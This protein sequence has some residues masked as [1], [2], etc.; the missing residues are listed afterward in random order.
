MKNGRR[1]VHG[2]GAAVE[3]A[4][5][6]RCVTPLGFGG[7]GWRCD[8]AADVASVLPEDYCLHDPSAQTGLSTSGSQRTLNVP[9]LPARVNRRGVGKTR[10]CAMN[11]TREQRLYS[12]MAHGQRFAAN[13]QPMLEVRAARQDTARGPLRRA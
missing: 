8:S 5:T 7:T 12:Q 3:G 9:R 13:G 6:E 1:P 4:D 10:Q 11:R 2:P